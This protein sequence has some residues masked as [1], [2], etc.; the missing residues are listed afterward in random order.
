MMFDKWNKRMKVKQFHCGRI[1]LSFQSIPFR[2]KII[3]IIKDRRGLRDCGYYAI[4]LCTQLC[5]TWLRIVSYTF[6]ASGADSGVGM[7]FSIICHSHKLSRIHINNRTSWIH[8]KQERI[9]YKIVNREVDTTDPENRIY[10]QEIQ[11]KIHVSG[12]CG[13]GN[14]TSHAAST[15]TIVPGRINH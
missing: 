1:N 14:G 12:G 4:C 11:K 8:V 7:E 6:L 3:N 13:N 15:A 9:V 5:H 2:D 10:L